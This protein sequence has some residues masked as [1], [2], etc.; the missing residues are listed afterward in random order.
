MKLFE[1]LA[2]AVLTVAIFFTP[3]PAAAAD[4]IGVAIGALGT[5][6][7]YESAYKSLLSLGN[8]VNAQMTA[9]RQDVKENGSDKNPRDLQ[10]VNAVMNQ[11]VNAGTYELRAN[12]LPFIWHVNDSE[13]F[14]AA[15]YPMNYVTVNRGLV[16]VLN[17][18]ENQI[19]AVLAHEMTHGIR[20]H[21]AKIYA[22]AVA[23]QVGAMMVGVNVDNANI[24]WGRVPAMVKYSVAKDVILPLEY[25]ADEGGFYLMTSAGFNPGGAAAAMARMDYYLRFETRDFLEFDA[26]DTPNEQTFNDHADT[27]VRE[28]KLSELMTDYSCGHVTVKKSDRQYKVFI[29]GKEV[30]IAKNTGGQQNASTKAYYFAGGL[31]RA[32]HDYNSIS[33]WNFRAGAG[34]SVDFLTDSYVF[35]QLREIAFVENIGA[36][37]RDAVTAAYQKDKNRKKYLDAEK[38]RLEAWKKVKADALY[39]DTRLARQLRVNADAYNDYDEGELA[40]KEIARAINAKNQDNHA[41]CLAIRGRAKAIVKDFTGALEDANAAVAQDSTNLYNFLNRSDVRRMRGETDLALADIDAAIKIDATNP[42]PYQLRGNIFD[43]LGDTAS[44]EENF[45]KCYELSK[46]NSHLIPLKYLEK[47]DA[48]TAEKI[49]KANPDAETNS[50]DEP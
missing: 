19:A 45:R 47:I 18:D 41:E 49:R 43:K 40:L 24:N 25:E 9:R 8:N 36:K 35:R 34:N 13:K 38:K 12:S 4:G 3:V 46:K 22:N 2:A 10:I 21:S 7:S 33:A 17:Y 14:N 23:R 42:I 39:A 20:Q 44:A 27:D 5:W 6:A 11:L 16:Q 48:K 37:I 50:A 1:K 26:H 30:Y 29:D 28:K 32:F 31:A 15:C